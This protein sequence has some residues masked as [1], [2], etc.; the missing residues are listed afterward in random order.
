ML[1]CMNIWKEYEI[2]NKEM[3]IIYMYALY[4]TRKRGKEGAKER[5]REEEREK[6][7]QCKL[8]V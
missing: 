5:E 8:S 1:I 2:K 6:K 7:K 3:Y 4:Y